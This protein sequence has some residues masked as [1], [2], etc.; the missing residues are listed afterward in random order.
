MGEYAIR[1]SG[2][3]GKEIDAYIGDLLGVS[4][5]LGLGLRFGELGLRG[6][7]DG[8]ASAEGTFADL[9][10]ET[11]DVVKESCGNALLI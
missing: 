6:S 4:L 5:L 7:G 10:V 8:L 3:G 9:L 11:L 1:E 2:G